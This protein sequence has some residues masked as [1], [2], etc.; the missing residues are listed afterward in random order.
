M[1][2]SGLGL[3]KR[4]LWCV[5]PQKEDVET[6]AGYLSLHQLNDSSVLLKWMPNQLMNGCYD[7]QK[8]E[9]DRR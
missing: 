5:I 3:S 9:G 1:S 7:N 8:D 2:V 4:V 6:L